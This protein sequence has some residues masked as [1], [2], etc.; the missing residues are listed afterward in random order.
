MTEGAVDVMTVE[1][2]DVTTEVVGRVAEEIATVDADDVKAAVDAIA[3]APEAIAET[4]PRVQNAHRAATPTRKTNNDGR[5][6]FA[7]FSRAP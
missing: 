3:I 6:K 4:M 5:R 2:V 1:A 7:C